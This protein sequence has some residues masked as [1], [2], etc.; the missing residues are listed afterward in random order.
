METSKRNRDNDSG[1]STTSIVGKR[2]GSTTE[3]S[4]TG[5]SDRESE[6]NNGNTGAVAPTKELRTDDAI[7]KKP[8]RKPKTMTVDPTNADTDS[9]YQIE[10]ARKNQRAFRE[11]KAT[12]LQTL[13]IE[14]EAL[15]QQVD[16][17][18]RLRLRVSELE[19]E[20]ELL[21]LK[22][23][24]FSF[25]NPMPTMNDNNTT[26][27]T[28]ATTTAAS[29]GFSFDLQTQN[30]F[31][32]TFA[33]GLSSSATPSQLSVE[34]CLEKL[35]GNTPPPNTDATATDNAT[36]DFLAYRQPS[37]QPPVLA[38]VNQNNDDLLELLF[39]AE[40]IP[41]QQQF[42]Q[43]QQ[44]QKQQLTQQDQ[45]AYTSSF[46]TLPSLSNELVSHV[47]TV[48]AM[49]KSL[50]SLQ[51]IPAVVDE[52]TDWF[53]KISLI[54]YTPDEMK[55]KNPEEHQQIEDLKETLISVAK[56]EDKSAVVHI[57]DGCKNSHPDPPLY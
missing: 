22:N 43:Q 15:R 41:A 16:N 29:Q 30:N 11:R 25:I 35:N 24:A 32:P 27:S 54:G 5:S 18:E 6:G 57:L 10:R 7:R 2:H 14:V 39:A 56:G 50:P 8:G 55:E 17:E 28:A 51:K 49:L 13:Q 36:A 42:S 12:Q 48:N 9:V 1:Y 40:Q 44:Q 53:A 38:P 20:N 3:S 33:P 45:S 47:A 46:T 31:F 26:T 34:E 37:A 4:V 23:F 19:A 52:L 21:K